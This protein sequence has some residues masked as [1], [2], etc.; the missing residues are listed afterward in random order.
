MS[1]YFP[2]KVISKNILVDLLTDPTLR[3]RFGV[4]LG[5]GCSFSSGVP[6]TSGIL[7]N[8][9]KELYR[10]FNYQEAIDGKQIEDWLKETNRLQDP[11][12]AY[13]DALEWLRPNPRL[14]RL[15]LE[16]YF[17]GI[18]P[19]PAY[20]A[21]ARLVAKGTFA[22]VYT[23]N[24]DDLVER[25]YRRFGSIRVVTHDQQAADVD[26]RSG[27]PTLYKLHGDFLFDN[28]KNTTLECQDLPVWEGAK[29][30]VALAESGLIVIGYSGNDV[31]IMSLLDRSAQLGI[32]LGLYWLGLA[33]SEPSDRVKSL[34]EKYPRV[35]YCP[36]D[37]FDEFISDLFIRIESH[38][39]YSESF[40][41]TQP[42]RPFV[43]HES[44]VQ[45]LKN[46]IE[47]ALES[48]SCPII[49]VVGLPGVGKTAVAQNVVREMRSTYQSIVEIPG[50]N[51]SLSLVDFL[52]ECRVR[53]GV[54]QFQH[55]GLA[56]TTQAILSA[57]SKTKT[58]LFL[59]NFDSA[60]SDIFEFLKA[61]P[62]PSN[63]LLTLR[64]LSQDMKDSISQVVAL[65]HS[66][67]TDDEMRELFT[68][69]ISHSAELRHK[70]ENL[71]SIAIE[72][73]IQAMRGW[74]EALILF[75][76]KM[77]NP[78]VPVSD[79]ERF[80]NSPDLYSSL[81]EDI[82]SQ[83][84]EI[85]REILKYAVAFPNSFSA[86][87][88][89]SLTSLEAR[90]IESALAQLIDRGVFQRL[91]ETRFVVA[92]P[93]VTSFLKERL[94]VGTEDEASL[95]VRQYVAN[96][97][98]EN[99]GQP[100]FDWSNFRRIDSE[101]ENVKALLEALLRQR[102][103]RVLTAVYRD[104]FSYMVERGHWL[105][106]DHLCD[107]VL[108]SNLP[109]ILK[110]DWLI[111][112]S[113]IE[114]YLRGD[115]TSSAQ[116][117]EEALRIRAIYKRH[118]FEA[119][120]RAALAFA[121]SFDFA[122]ASRHL[123]S[124]KRI[125]RKNYASNSHQFIDLNNLVG[126]F[127]LQRVQ[128]TFDRGLL[129]RALRAFNEAQRLSDSRPDPNTREI[130]VALIGK[131]KAYELLGDTGRALAIAKQASDQAWDLQW[132][133]GIAES[134][135]LVSR[136]A[137]RQ[138]EFYLSSSAKDLSDRIFKQLGKITKDRVN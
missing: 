8:A 71:D 103:H 98:H 12:T 20:F 121:F 33:A 59:D 62:E 68:H 87:A 138:N 47:S 113:W 116:Y 105:Y 69:L 10:I 83:V 120:R 44:G 122:R 73:V 119:H 29:L 65:P 16:Q 102:E 30:E 23:T 101:Y 9:K 99:G 134:N 111:W 22:P 37:G 108:K 19:A 131:A 18:E 94:G 92:H 79:Y 45:T 72:R 126:Q 96:W 77:N 85:E 52:D 40:E 91:T 38:R 97:V 21:F 15:Y 133:R 39:M 137:H 51:R 63:T 118:A 76:G 56:E 124:A 26:V 11:A 43:A 123:A 49:I 78:T 82:F 100:A 128:V 58:L 60:S 42:Q 112:K 54:G 2:R 46:E 64:S 17:L 4:L 109:S 104:I 67:L 50:K 136:L 90:T 129:E 125:C 75:L 135:E 95:E 35:N 24:F 5:A 31:S 107:K 32:P 3:G 86:A 70:F 27:I 110:A 93:L 41:Y 74:P 106:T 1:E 84:V 88:L 14:R 115:F 81:L 6:L 34:V 28:M 130:G 89:V 132:L 114:F 53:L 80:L 127:M 55:L 117:A 25:A 13:G 61:V 36:I 66:G 48:S 7:Q 57:L